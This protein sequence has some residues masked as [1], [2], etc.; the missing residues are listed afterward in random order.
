M[1]FKN[2]LFL[3]LF[4]P[5]GL[6]AQ[7]SKPWNKPL[8]DAFPFHYGFA[9]SGGILD[10]SVNQSNF[11][12]NSDTVYSVEGHAQPAFGASIVGNLRLNENWDLRFIPG[13]Y[14]GQRNLDY[15]YKVDANKTDSTFDNHVMKIETTYLQFPVLVKYRAVRE[16][17]YRPYVVFGATY[18]RDMAAR[19]KIKEEELPK[20]RLKPN[21]L[22]LELGFGVDYYFPDFKFSSEIRFSYGLLNMVNYDNT[23]YTKVFDRLGTKM[24]TMFIYFE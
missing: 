9:F 7:K 4:I 13:M 16:N 22:F 1:S 18:A 14:F 11:I 6:M 17:N 23:E 20:I 19:K 3:L 5:V 24:V 10:F 21:D 12:N 2:L 15:L 8:Y